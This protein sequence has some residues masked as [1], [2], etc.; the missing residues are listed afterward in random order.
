MLTKISEKG[1]VAMFQ[2]AMNSQKS[3]ILDA[4][5]REYQSDQK[6]EEYVL[7]DNVPSLR[8]W[9]GSRQEKEVGE[10]IVTVANRKFESS[11]KIS[12]D[13]LNRGNSDRVI[14]KVSQLATAAQNHWNKLVIEKLISA[15]AENAYNGNVFF[16]SQNNNNITV[17]ISTLPIPSAEQG[18]ITAPSTATMQL[19]IKAGIESIQNQVD[20]DGEP[21]AEGATQFASIVPVGLSGANL[22]ASTSKFLSNGASNSLAA[23]YSLGHYATPRLNANASSFYVVHTASQ[24]P[25]IIRQSERMNVSMLGA[26]S[27]YATLNDAW[28]FTIMAS[29]N[30]GLYD[31]QNI[32]RVT[33]I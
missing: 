15:T 12:L 13:V 20:G 22:D 1:V 32:C 16:S 10:N 29:R 14:E 4:I 2:R 18:S 28:L 25:T 5:S 17:D 6:L 23:G 11:V 21:I 7:L 3:P 26:G 33:L 30:V 9:T 27:D 31:Y 24:V 8:A 19:A